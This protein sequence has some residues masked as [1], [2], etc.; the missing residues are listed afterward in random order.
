MHHPA[1]TSGGTVGLTGVVRALQWSALICWVYVALVGVLAPYFLPAHF[2]DVLPVRTDIVG[3]LSFGASSL[4]LVVT[5]LLR[6]DF[7]LLRPRRRASL[8][9]SRS[10][11]LHAWLGWAYVS[12][13]SISHRATLNLHLTH[14]ASWPT[15]GQFGLS[16]FF[17]AVVSM[18]I[19]FSLKPRP[20][21]PTQ[22]VSVNKPGP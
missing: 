5:G 21:E 7:R 16:S 13:N 14:L 4:L 10:V 2:E 6:P 8:A 22:D 11:A 12:A 20:A 17:A 9:I 3:I 19:C 15:E 18:C 1:S